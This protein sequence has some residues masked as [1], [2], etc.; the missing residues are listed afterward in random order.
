[1][2]ASARPAAGARDTYDAFADAYDAFT[3]DH[4]YEHWV[5]TLEAL[6]R[7]QGLRGSRLLDVACGTG[8]S[9]L[10]WL[11]R[12]YEVEGCD[13]SPRMLARAEEKAGGRARLAVAD[14]RELPGGD[15]VDLVTC[16]GDAVNYLLEPADLAAAFASVA[17]RLR[18][19]GLYLFD[20]NSLRTYR[21]D[22]ACTRVVRREGWDLRWTGHGDGRLGPGG[23]A[24]ATV[25]VRRRA[26][27]HPLTT[28]SHHVQRHH[29]QALVRASL[30]AAGLR[31]LNVHGQ[32]RD[33]SLD[34]GFAEV[35]H[36]KA[37][38][39][40]RKPARRPRERR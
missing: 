12:G 11:D 31:C 21:Q 24:S 9:L 19:G 27:G 13:L 15:P 40:A 14:M 34:P 29:P 37:L 33:G 36:S 1:M 3:W 38:V 20:L 6:A 39:V 8:K 5:S 17:G 18:P 22:F 26:P 32:H 30:E 28:A 2:Q 4:D 10:P 16:L 25:T 7:A 23:L 35:A